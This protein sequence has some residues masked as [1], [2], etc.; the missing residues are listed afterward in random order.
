MN[1]NREKQFS[2]ENGYCHILPYHLVIS[3]D[4]NPNEML[5]RKDKNS[6]PLIN[7]FIGIITI[8]FS[9]LG[10]FLLSLGKTNDAAFLL[11]CVPF[12]IYFFFKFRNRSNVN[13]I[14]RSRIMNIRLG[15]IMLNPAFIILFKDSKGKLKER[16]LV[17]RS[18]D[19]DKILKAMHL[20]SSEKLMLA[21]S[22]QFKVSAKNLIKETNEIIK[23]ETSVQQQPNQQTTKETNYKRT[24][25]GYLKDY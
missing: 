24:K 10:I 21:D 17:M 2:T 12:N 16:I 5:R 14:D 13:V 4:G 20:L 19:S 22:Q 18:N 8:V 25:E 15:K 9:V 6:Y 1:S 23:T 11:L 7:L 3:Q